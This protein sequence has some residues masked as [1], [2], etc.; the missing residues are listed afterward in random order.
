VLFHSI[1]GELLLINLHHIMD[2]IGYL[3]QQSLRI[4]VIRLREKRT[5]ASTYVNRIHRKV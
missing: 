4:I 3:D 1:P 2:D 5:L